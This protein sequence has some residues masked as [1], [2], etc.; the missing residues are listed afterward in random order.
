MWFQPGIPV[1]CGL[2]DAYGLRR[3]VGQVEKRSHL[4]VWLNG[5]GRVP[6]AG[7]GPTTADAVE[8][9]LDCTA[10]DGFLTAEL[11]RQR[12]VV[13]RA[14]APGS[15][16][17]PKPNKPNTFS[18]VKESG[19]VS[20]WLFSLRLYFEATRTADEHKVAFAVTFLRGSAALWWQAHLAQV[21]SRT[22]T[23]LADWSQFCTAFQAQFAAV[24]SVKDC[25]GCNQDSQPENQR[26]GLH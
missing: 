20:A 4:S 12:S 18:S 24:N 1:P 25:Q 26:A 23:R 17:A 3:F 11:Q 8:P 22:A 6:A 15:A 14:T 19:L 9:G 7:R 13:E 16:G 2:G 10:T 5:R 21:D